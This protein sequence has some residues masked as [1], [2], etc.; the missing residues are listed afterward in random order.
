M[1]LVFLGLVLKIQVTRYLSRFDAFLMFA[2]KL[3]RTLLIK[4]FISRHSPLRG[5]LQM[6]RKSFLIKFHE[7]SDAF[8]SKENGFLLNFI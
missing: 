6:F 4:F 2:N 7:E 1:Y 5:T 3:N 8:N